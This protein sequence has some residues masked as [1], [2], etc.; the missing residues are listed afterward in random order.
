MTLSIGIS[1]NINV[2]LSCPP[3]RKCSAN[4]T[5]CL[6]LRAKERA[7]CEEGHFQGLCL[8][9]K[10]S[11]LLRSKGYEVPGIDSDRTG[12]GRIIDWLISV[13]LVFFCSE[14]AP[15]RG[16]RVRTV[17]PTISQVRSSTRTEQ[18]Q[19]YV[20]DVTLTQKLYVNFADEKFPAAMMWRVCCY[21]QRL[22]L[23]YQYYGT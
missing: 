18:L 6:R 11:R 22:S 12:A 3:G 23:R 17:G 7:Q 19:Q 1:M 2:R 20:V 13:I 8:L 4:P 21:V 9:W 14:D 5:R 10:R 15:D 16:Y